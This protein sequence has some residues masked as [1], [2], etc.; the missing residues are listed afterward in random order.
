MT[1]VPEHRAADAEVMVVIVDVV[2]PEVVRRMSELPRGVGRMQREVL[3]P[4]GITSTGLYP[5]EVEVLRLMAEGLDTTQI[6]HRL[7]YSERT[8]KNVLHGL[9]TRMHL[10]NRPH[11]V[12][13]ALREGLI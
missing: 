8:V 4:L 10:R 3:G 1:V 9:M 5:R 6:A 11:A 12:A 7:V 13:Y 2:T